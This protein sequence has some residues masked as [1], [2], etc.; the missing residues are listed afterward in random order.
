MIRLKNIN[1]KKNNINILKNINFSIEKG[2]LI[3]ILGLNGSGKSQLAMLLSGLIDNYEGEYF[4]EKKIINNREILGKKCGI[5]FQKADN[6][7]FSSIVKNDLAFGL[8]NRNVPQEEMKLKVD[9]ILKKLKIEDL[10]NKNVNFLSGGEKQ[11]AAI[12]SILILDFEL[13]IF[14]E[15]TSMLDD[16]S[17]K[18]IF[19][20]IKEL[21]KEGKT[22]IY[23][24]HKIEEISIAD[25][26]LIMEEGEIKEFLNAKEINNSILKKY[27]LI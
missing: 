20:I 19:E 9:N 7:F 8:E 3:V 10:K 4:W 6:Q 18:Q 26:V 15:V 24:T 27:E 2:D 22:I 12:A 14:D 11:K 23:I 25:K 17:S 1:L 5:V 21:H 16:S 13:L